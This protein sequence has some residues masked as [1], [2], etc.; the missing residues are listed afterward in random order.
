MTTKTTSTDDSAEIPTVNEESPGMGD[1]K[2][3]HNVVASIV[4]LA[5]LEVTGTHSVGN[6]GFS[7]GITELFKGKEG[8]SSGVRV[9]E[10][11]AGNYVIEVRVVLRFGVELA[12]VAL[13]I[14]QNVK[15]QVAR[16][17]MKGVAKV[18]VIIENV[19]METDTTESQ[20]DEYGHN[21]D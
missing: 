3:N 1:I 7:E 20:R 15:E 14:Q 5:A 9:G 13:E 18:D 4:R 12:K 16:M 10:D 2:I 21:A 17:T 19:R 8:A 6:G 11:E